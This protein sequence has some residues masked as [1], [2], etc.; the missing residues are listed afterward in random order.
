MEEE[1]ENE[2]ELSTNK[3]HPLPPQ[4][5]TTTNT[6]KVTPHSM[7]SS[8]KIISPF[9]MSSSR[10]KKEDKENDILKVFKKEKLNIPLIYVIKQ[11]P[12]HINFLKELCTNNRA[13]NLKG[14]CYPNF[15]PLIF[16][17]RKKDQ[18]I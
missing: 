16:M 2:I 4:I 7:N 15:D 3:K 9:P 14:C 6:Q 10:S 1:E 5:K 18:K 12:D 13:Y 8:F 11:I 17:F